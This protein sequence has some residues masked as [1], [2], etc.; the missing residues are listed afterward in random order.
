MATQMLSLFTN[1][2][3]YLLTYK[4]SQDHIELLFSCIRSRGGS[5]NNP[6]CL[7]MKYALRKMLMRNAITASRNANCVDFTGCNNIIPLF[8]ARKHKT[9]I[10]KDSKQVAV[11]DQDPEQED[12]SM[13]VM[14]EHLN[15]GHSEFI[16]NVLFYIAGYIVFK[17][18]DNLS[19]SQC[20]RCLLVETSIDDHDY[21]VTRYHEAGKA[22]A[23]TTFVNKGGLQIPSTSVYRCIEYCEHVFRATVMGDDN[24]H[25][26]NNAKL[27]NTMIIKVCQHFTLVS[28]LPLFTDHED[29]DNEAVVEDDHTTQ[30]TKRVVVVISICKFSKHDRKSV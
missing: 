1:P 28:T 5:N 29:G 25:I 10:N 30:L 7:Q 23:F 11:P 9:D 4:F 6:N 19:C 24:Q 8:H 15:E 22:S 27:K 21:T 12:N 20:K 17:L 14:L 26:S 3:K 16:S 18:I 13:N 2:F